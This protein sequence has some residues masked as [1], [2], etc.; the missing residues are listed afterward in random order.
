MKYF[1]I[2][3]LLYS[4]PSFGDAKGEDWIKPTLKSLNVHHPFGDFYFMETKEIWKDVVGYEGHYQVSNKNRAKY[5][6][7]IIGNE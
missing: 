5:H 1:L 2:F 4:F 3:I 7:A 6:K